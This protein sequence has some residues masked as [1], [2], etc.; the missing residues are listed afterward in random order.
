MKRN[1]IMFVVVVVLMSGIAQAE[2]IHQYTFNGNAN[3]S[4][5]SADATNYGADLSDYGWAKL[6]GAGSFL[7]LGGPSIAINTL[8][9]GFTLELWSKQPTIDQGYS[10][11]AA[12]GGTQ[13]WWGKR[14]V[15]ISTTRG[16]QVSRA[17]MTGDNDN[18]G[19]E[20]E[21]GVN[22]TEMNDGLLHQYVLTVGLFPCCPGDATYLSYYLDGVLI[23]MINIGDRSIS[24]LS[25][26][27]AYLGK[28]LYPGDP[29][30]IGDIEEFN[31]Y[32][33]A[34]LCCDVA[35]LYMQGPVPVPE[36][37]TMVLLGLGS[38]ALLRRRK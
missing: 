7:D 36:P 18:P 25:N 31:I 28:G 32:N 11:T 16:D 5:G 37:A 23:G 20:T 10:M 26:D 38:L 1:C 19:Y 22:W 27:F 12:F 9:D 8:T 21:A 17:M 24:A 2:L 3:D 14:Y 4:V 29:S 35:L 34:L 30:V 33:E 13:E 6:D 15:A